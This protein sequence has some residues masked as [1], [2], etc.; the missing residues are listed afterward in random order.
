[1]P[2]DAEHVFFLCPHFTGEKKELKERLGSSLTPKIFVEVM[3][4]TEENWTA[5]S[6]SVTAVMK[7][8]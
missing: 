3:L 6:C 5:I 2:E 7:R 8:L 1:M 4:E